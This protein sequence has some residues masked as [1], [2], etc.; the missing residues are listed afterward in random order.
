M[1]YIMVSLFS[2]S[3]ILFAAGINYEYLPFLCGFFI[4]VILFSYFYARPL[5]WTE[6]YDYEKRYYR[7]I[8]YLPSNWEPK[9]QDN[10]EN[11]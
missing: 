2:I 7:E 6:M 1:A 11:N 3:A 5:T 10:D 9:K 8:F 4:N